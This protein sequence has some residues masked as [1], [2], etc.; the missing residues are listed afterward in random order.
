MIAIL[1][2][3]YGQDMAWYQ[4]PRHEAANILGCGGIFVQVDIDDGLGNGQTLHIDSDESW[5]Y[6]E[7]V[8]WKQD[9]SAGAVGFVEPDGVTMP[10]LVNDTNF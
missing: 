5:R 2:H 7:S 6:L 1:A 9:T 10:C 8:A 4:L 3:S